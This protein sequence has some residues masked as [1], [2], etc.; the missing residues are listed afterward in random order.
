MNNTTNT[1]NSNM[2]EIV[3]CKKYDNIVINKDNVI[4]KNDT[5]VINSL[6]SIEEI[7]N[8]IKNID[9]RPSWDEYFII[10]S[11]LISKR[12][13]CNRLQV[14]CVITKNNRIVTTGYNGFIS[15]TPH[16]G[17]VRDN[18][19]QMTIHAETNAIADAAKRG[20]SLSDSTAY[21]TH[22]PCINCCKVLIASGIKS[23]IYGNDYKNDELVFLLCEK[24]E[25]SIKKFLK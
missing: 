14:G 1:A 24:G 7:I 9:F 13:T 2:D 25:V 12:S 17:V 8:L 4:S 5:G 22:F 23:I 16:V 18:H 10:I 15:G 3:D 19:E 20:V 21:I 11:Y 6:D